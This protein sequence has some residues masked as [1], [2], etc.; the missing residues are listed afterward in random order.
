M[1]SYFVARQALSD[2]AHAVHDRSRCPP[3]SFPLE[4]GVEYLGEFLDSDQAVR[5]AR[6]RFPE[7]RGCACCTSTATDRLGADVLGF[8]RS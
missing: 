1:A 2:G 4:A 7:A 3:G 6:L 5:V 8:L